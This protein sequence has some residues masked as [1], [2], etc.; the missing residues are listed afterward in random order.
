[1]LGGYRYANNPHE[2]FEN[3]FKDQEKLN[4]VLDL[5][6]NT[7][8]SLFG[9]AFGGLENKS[10]FKCQS[11]VVQVPCMLEELYKGATKTVLY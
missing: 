9:H 8:G 2:I 4:S 6:I 7:E 1:M 5:R 3:F 11:L 10:A